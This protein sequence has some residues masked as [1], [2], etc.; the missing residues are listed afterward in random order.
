MS[1]PAQTAAVA[2]FGDLN[3]DTS[4]DVHRFPIGEGDTLFRFD[5]I[6]DLVGG[7]AANVACGLAALGHAVR[8]GSVVGGDRIGDLVL[9]RVAGKGV[10]TD[11]VRRDW[12]VTARTVVLVDEHGHRRC[13]NDP[14]RV[15]DYR[16]PP[17]AVD[18]V[19]G[20]APVA[21]LSTQSWCRHVAEQARRRGRVVVVDLQAIADVDDYHDD[22]LRHAHVVLF[23]TERL[24]RHSHDFMR[25]LWGRYRLDAA[26][27]THGADG[28][29][30]G[31]PG[32]GFHH[33]P[34]FDLRPVVDRTG[35]GDAFAAGFVSALLRGRP[36]RE[37]VTWGQVTAAH[38]IGERGSTNGFPD[39][40]GLDRL[41]AGARADR[42]GP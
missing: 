30:L 25:D 34:R 32:G 26:V 2:V 7:A 1:G 13:I 41:V 15:H 24:A 6:R 40:A 5:G 37:A 29:T 20:D 3:L 27:A 33:E 42:E 9:E 28:A 10:A 21:A 11:F 36:Y 38:K 35:A 16:Y 17:D 19:L 4:V 39:P 14:K 8:F 31:L 18:V 23:S 22:F 12:P